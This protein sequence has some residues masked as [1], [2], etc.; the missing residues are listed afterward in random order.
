MAAPDD[1]RIAYARQARADLLTRDQL[2]GSASP[3]CQSLHFL[4]MGCEKLAKAFLC[5]AGSDPSSLQGS[6]A[7][8]AKQLPLVARSQLEDEGA[9]PGPIRDVVRFVKRLAREIELL[10]PA[11]DD[12][13]RRPDNCEYPW[14]DSAGR[15]RIPADFTFAVEALLREPSG[16]KA[17]RILQ[18]AADRLSA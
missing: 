9:K 7:Y 14:E 8:V 11:V 6:H 10:A 17:L 12:G 4:Q 5:A 13:G 2:D 18:R 16:K 3:P 15:V 1:W